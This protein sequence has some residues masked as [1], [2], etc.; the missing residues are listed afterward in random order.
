[1]LIA[2][3][4]TTEGGDTPT[5]G[6]IVAERINLPLPDTSGG[7]T[8]TDAL[9]R[10]RSMRDFQPV[11]LELEHVSQL[12]WAAQGV[13]SSAGKRTAPSAGALYPL[14]LYLATTDGRY[15]Y[16]PHNHQLEALGNDDVRR[17]LYRAALDQEAVRQAPAVFIVTAVYSRTR[18]KYGDRAERYVKLE[19]GHAAQNLLL[20]AVSLE[21]GAVPIGAFRDHDVQDVL[22]LPDDHEPLYLIAVGNP[23]D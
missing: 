2:G 11:P 20:Q 23:A 22:A 14:E 8:L 21:L 17:D 9:A 16:D 7:G 19:A 18:Q 5:S 15:H 3:C 12:M 6:A 4:A 10:R 13:T 1:M